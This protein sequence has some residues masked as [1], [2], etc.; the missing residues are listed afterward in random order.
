MGGSDEPGPAPG[1]GAEAVRLAL[2]LA[3]LSAAAAVPGAAWPW[4]LVGP[5]AAYAAICAAVPGLRGRP[6]WLGT[7]RIDAVTAA[8][9][10]AVTVLSCAALLG[11]WS[12]VR[13]DL[14]AL[15]AK[16]PMWA[17]EAPILFAAVFA[18]GNAAFEDVIFRGVMQEAL[19]RLR[20]AAVAVA[21][22]AALFGMVH[23]E[24]FPSGAVGVA[25]AGVFGAALGLLR[26]RTGGLLAPLIPHIAAD[27]TIIA[28]ILST[29]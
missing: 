10:A 22:Q 19:T 2:L 4:Y 11:W 29:A 26:L 23:R 9:T 14:S 12:A 21:V 25:M 1:E 27:A 18:V 16:A 17:G 15:R 28:V 5:L 13:P 6:A 20:G 7:G 3:L 24:G 8:A